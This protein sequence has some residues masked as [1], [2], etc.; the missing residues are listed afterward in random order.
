MKQHLRLASI[1]LA[2]ILVMATTAATTSVATGSLEKRAQAQHADNEEGISSTTALV[3]FVTNVEFVR[4]HLEKAIENKQAGSTELAVAHAGHPIEEVYTLIHQDISVKDSQLAS[5][6]KSKLEALPNT[7]SSDS[8]STFTQKVTEINGLL[9][10]AVQKVAAGSE[11]QEEA[12]FTIEII[13]GLLETANIE[14]EEAVANGQIIEMIEYQDA[15]AFINRANVLFKTIQTGIDDHEAEEIVEFMD[16]LNFRVASKTDPSQVETVIQGIIRELE[17]ASS[18]ANEHAEFVANLEFIKGHLAQA[19]A[20]KQA[21]STELAVA[22]AGHPIEEVYALIEPEISEHNSS[23]NTKLKEALTNLANQIHSLS[24]SAVQTMVTEIN[25]MLDEAGTSVVSEAERN[26]PKF[27]AMVILLLL[28][29]AQV[30]YE[31]AVENGEIVEM[32]E[33]QDSTAFIARSQIISDSI[34]SKIPAH[35]AEEIQEFY[36]ELN[37]LTKSNASF[38]QVKTVFGGIIHEYEEIFGLEAM[39]EEEPGEHENSSTTT[40]KSLG[41]IENIRKI[42]TKLSEAYRAGNYAEAD[43]LAVDAYLNNFEFVEGDL[44]KSGNRALMLEIE[45]LMRIELREMIKGKAS[46]GEIDA[47]IAKINSKLDQAVNALSPDTIAKTTA[48]RGYHIVR[49]TITQQSEP[50]DAEGHSAHQVVYMV[51]PTEGMIYE[52]SITFTSTRSVDVFVYHDVTWAEA[53]DT[54]GLNIHKVNG[55]LYAVTTLLKN[56]S[57]GTVQFAGAGI[58]AHVHSETEGEGE[59]NLVASMEVYGRLLS[60]Q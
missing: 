60:K 59:Y 18:A 31:E 23:L 53:E 47:H 14:Y 38:E 56:A 15:S 6:L 48:T 58:L 22:H 42:L 36:A 21:G 13:T 43:R 27:N 12:N 9:D 45:Q 46:V 17:E 57:S 39:E 20:N 28:A 1:A 25:G 11:A 37:S 2:A 50:H 32:I 7:V 41:Y 33:Y 8:I 26:D 44:E 34:K 3:R 40:T 30:E 55:R 24:T 16:E 4:G 19:V 51:Y 52:G 54:A 29:T 35:K 5:N 10:Q 49:T